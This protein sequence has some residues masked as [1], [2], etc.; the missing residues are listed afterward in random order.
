M[1][2]PLAEFCVEV[3]IEKVGRIGLISTKS[4]SLSDGIALA[5]R[6]QE[7]DQVVSCRSAT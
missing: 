4:P 7:L 3:A 6:R 2:H 5:A 1:V